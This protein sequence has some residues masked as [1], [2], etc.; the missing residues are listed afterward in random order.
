MTNPVINHVPTI[1]QLRY[2]IGA[3]VSLRLDCKEPDL[4]GT[5]F[6]LSP[7]AVTAPFM[8]NSATTSPP[9]AGWAVSV[10]LPNRIFLSLTEDDTIALGAGGKSV[11]WHWVVWL[12]HMTAPERIMV[13]HGDLG[14]LS[15]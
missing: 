2:A 1:V 15:P 7:Y 12:D 9:I 4:A 6:D 8:P 14:L 11:V 5:P 10:E 13:A 3:S